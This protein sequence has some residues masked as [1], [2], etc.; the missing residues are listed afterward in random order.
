MSK[1]NTARAKKCKLFI[2]GVKALVRPTHIR[3]IRLGQ[4]AAMSDGQ[5]LAF[6]WYTVGGDIREA[7]LCYVKQQKRSATGN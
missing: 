6:D 1:V 7:M 4:L 2:D 3:D 5:A